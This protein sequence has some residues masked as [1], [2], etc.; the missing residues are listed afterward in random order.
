MEYMNT[1]N[2]I[3]I[4]TEKMR[5]TGERYKVSVLPKTKS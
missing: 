1:E 5:T 2:I 4:I 3:F